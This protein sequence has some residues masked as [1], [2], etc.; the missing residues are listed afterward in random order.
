MLVVEERVVRMLKKFLYGL[1]A[2]LVMVLWGVTTFAKPN[3]QHTVEVAGIVHHKQTKLRKIGSDPDPLAGYTVSK[4]VK[5]LCMWGLGAAALTMIIF[6]VAA[7]EITTPAP[8]K[9]KKNNH[10]KYHMAN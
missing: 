5:E 2:V 10:T 6:P 3:S 7:W 8:T 9:T 4:D 1:L